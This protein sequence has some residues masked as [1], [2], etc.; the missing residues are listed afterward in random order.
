MKASGTSHSLRLLAAFASVLLFAWM[1]S[2]TGLGTILDQTRLLGAGLVLLVLLSGFRHVLRA[3]VWQRCIRPED[4]NVSLVDLFSLRLVGDAITEIAPGGPLFGEPAKVLAASQYMP[5][6]S[7]A[8]SVFIENVI[9]GFAALLFM[10]SG[11]TLALLDLA[12]PHAFRWIGGGLFL[13][14]LLLILI[15]WLIIG[16][17]TLV[18]GR[19]CDYLKNIGLKW[20][21]LERYGQDLRAFEESVY[22]SFANRRS[23]LFL[24]LAIEFATN[25][26]GVAEAHLILRA[27]TTHASFTAAYLVESASRAVQFACAFV[28]FGL[29]VQEGAA[30]FTLKA[31]GYT[32]SEGVSLAIIRKIRTAFWAGIGLV[33]AGKFSVA[34][35]AEESGAS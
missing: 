29:G 27:T 3:V 23:I 30:A 35:G 14:L 15:A 16:R 21:V 24:M 7:S 22:D 2:R 6:L 11:V 20:T 17:R 32:V 18:L 28:P 13:G 9:Y 5:A 4:R 8:S 25:F 31:V 34:R 1:V 33:L 10:L 26:T 12:T 19:I